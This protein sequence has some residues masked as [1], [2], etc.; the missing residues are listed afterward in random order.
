MEEV[1]LLAGSGKE[2]L[3]STL[4]PS[5][6]YSVSY[7]PERQLVLRSSEVRIEIN[8]ERVD[9]FPFFRNY[10]LLEVLSCLMQIIPFSY[11]AGIIS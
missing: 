11:L 5:L 3:K 2:S 4:R 9:E 8:M 1:V 10:L 6:R 7:I